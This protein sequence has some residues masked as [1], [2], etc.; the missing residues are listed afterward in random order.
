MNHLH[1]W[2]CTDIPGVYVCDCGQGAKY[3]YF[4]Q[5]TREIEV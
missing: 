2:E 5:E 3:G 4:N 1:K